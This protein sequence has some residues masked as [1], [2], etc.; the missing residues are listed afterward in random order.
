MARRLLAVYG[1]AL[2]LIL[3]VA[4]ACVAPPL[5]WEARH[6]LAAVRA[7]TPDQW[8]QHASARL[9][10]SR[11]HFALPNIAAY[12]FNPGAPRLMEVNAQPER[13]EPA[14]ALALAALP[15]PLP[16][17]VHRF[18]TNRGRVALPAAIDRTHVQDVSSPPPRRF[19]PIPS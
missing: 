1:T 2:I 16:A 15:A 13:P 5:D 9:H 6:S 10:I 4:G 7:V 14:A 3:A 8:R 17:S 11:S 12:L 19:S 18:E